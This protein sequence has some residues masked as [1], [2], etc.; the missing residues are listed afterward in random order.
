MS[1]SIKIEKPCHEDWNKMKP[2]G[3]GKHCE[4]CNKAVIDFTNAKEDEI[5]NYLKQNSGQRVCGH[6]KSDQLTKKHSYTDRLLNS[7]LVFIEKRFSVRILTSSFSFIV[8]VLLVMIGCQNRTTGEVE[9]QKIDI[10]DSSGNMG[11]IGISGGK[12]KKSLFCTKL[13][14]VKIII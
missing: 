5:I 13:C 2:K 4:L 9:L 3:Q 8:G 10:K 1:E 12:V 6:F 7:L 14:K 11:S